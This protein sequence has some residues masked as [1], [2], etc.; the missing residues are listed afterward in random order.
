LTLNLFLALLTF[1]AIT[2]WTPGPNNTILMATGINHGFRRAL[3]MIFG[4]T[5]GFPLMIAIVGLGLGKVFETYPVIY[6]G[7]KVCGAAYMLWLAFKIATSV[8]S[9][10]ETQIQ[11]PM[12]FIGG[13][14][15]QWVNPKGWIMAVTALAAYTLPGSYYTSVAAVVLAFTLTGITSSTGWVLFGASLRHVMSDPRWFRLFNFGLAAALVA[16]LVPLLWH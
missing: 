6:T 16:S 1:A 14:L 4:V 2:S 8:P 7:L 13:V 12:S 9:N 5:F 10:G 11:K 3:P 15:F